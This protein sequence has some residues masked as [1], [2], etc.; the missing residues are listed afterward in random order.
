VC[1]NFNFGLKMVRDKRNNVVNHNYSQRSYKTDGYNSFSEFYP[2]Y[3]GEHCNK[4]N[5]RLHLIGTTNS[6]A[7]AM[8][9]LMT[10]FYVLLLAAMLQGYAF[11]WIGHFWF[12]KNKPATFKHPLYSL[13]GDFRMWFEVMCNKR[14]F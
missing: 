1:H 2:F 13:M 12:E 10:G 14:S 7:L 5:R 9:G 3:L 6:I 4:V 11:A 8:Y